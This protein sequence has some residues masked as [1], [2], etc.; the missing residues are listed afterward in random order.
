LTEARVPAPGP[1]LAAL[2]APLALPRPRIRALRKALLDYGLPLLLLGFSTITTTAIGARFMFNFLNGQPAVISENDLWPW[3]WLLAHPGRF[4]LG[5]PFSVALLG[6]LLTHEFGHYFAC[7]AHGVRATLPWVLPA[8]TL[9]GTAGAVIQIRSR[10][11]NR[12]ALVDVGIY[13]PLA[14]FLA[15]LLAVTIGL[16][17]SH[18]DPARHATALIGFG[19]PLTLK[20]MPW[21]LAPFHHGTPEFAQAICHPV[22]IAGW[23]GLF[24]TALNLIPGGQLDGGHLLFALSPR[25]HRW[26]TLALPVVLLAC[27]FFFWVGWVLWGALLVIPAMRRHPHV[28]AN[29]PLGMRH[30]LLC[31]VALVIFAL[32]FAAQPFAGSSILNYLR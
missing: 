6:I 23:V 27:G 25:W 30:T 28:P 8:P 32:T 12:R 10:I 17:L 24:I 18:S 20:L 7:R 2:T 31:M 21:L 22:L 4:H 14:G 29:E 3:P 13:G 5:W 19:E 9:S 15:S 16:L 1:S 26:I 11:P